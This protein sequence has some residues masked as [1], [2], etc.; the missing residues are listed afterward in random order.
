MIA[1]V[2]TL[3]CPFLTIFPFRP[4][5]FLPCSIQNFKVGTRW[6]H[7]DFASLFRPVLT[8]FSY[9]RGKKKEGV[10]IHIWGRSDLVGTLEQAGQ[11]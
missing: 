6:E 2:P 8:S 4:T 10:N 5:A 11:P 7:I 3:Q 9:K 1:R